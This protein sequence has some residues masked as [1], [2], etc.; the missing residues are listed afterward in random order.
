MKAVIDRIGE[1]FAVIVIPEKENLR[2]NIP[3][4]LLPAGSGEGDILT[5]SIE[6]DE[7]ATNEAQARVSR[8]IADLIRK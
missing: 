7:A 4:A 6:R 5:I 8:L 2:L 3:S 1:T